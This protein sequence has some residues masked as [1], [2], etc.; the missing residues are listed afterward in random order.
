MAELSRQ[1]DAWIWLTET[2]AVAAQET[3]A[4]AGGPDENYPFGL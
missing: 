4:Y 2:S 3:T 1:F